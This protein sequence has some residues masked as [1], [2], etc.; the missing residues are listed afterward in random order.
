M[1]YQCRVN[2]NIKGIVM[3]TETKHKYLAAIKHDLMKKIKFI[4]ITKNIK[5]VKHL[6]LTGY[7]FTINTLDGEV[8][9][10]A[11]IPNDFTKLCFS[12]SMLKS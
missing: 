3:N 7:T 4:P 11:T 12:S 8:T 2:S 9:N 6:L 5:T 10:V 1:W